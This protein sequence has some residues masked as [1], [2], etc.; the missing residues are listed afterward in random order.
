MLVSALLLAAL[1]TQAIVVGANGTPI[2]SATVTFVAA[3]G[4]KITARTDARGEAG[5]PFPAARIHAVAN[6]CL[7][8]DIPATAGTV[9]IQLSCTPPV[10]GSVSVAT[11]SLESIHRLPV[12]ASLMDGAQIAQS[13]A[14]TGDA[15]LRALPG[16]DMTRSNSRFTNYGQLR[17]S[18]SGAGQDRGLVLV[19]GVPAQDGFGGQIDWAAYP[20]N[21]ILRAELLRGAGSALYGSGAIGGVLSIS[22]FAPSSDWHSPPSALISLTAGSHVY[23]NLYANVA[24]PLAPKLTM[25]ASTEQQFM[26]Y[27]DLTPAYSTMHDNQAQ[28][29]SSM[30]SIRLR[31]D[32]SP[33]FYAM[34]GYRAGWDYQQQG[35]PNY[36]F[37]RR[38]YQN[39]VLLVH[40]TT[41]STTSIDYYVR[42][43]DVTNRADQF[44]A[45]PGVLR[46]TQ[47]VPSNESGLSSTWT[48]ESENSTLE[49]HGDAKF[50]NGES[51]QT[52]PTGSFQSLGSGVQDLGGLAAQET[53]LLPRTQIVAGARADTVSFYDGNIVSAKS[54]TVAAPSWTDRAVS[55]RI[56]VRYDLTRR[57]AFRISEGAGFRAPYLN[58]LVRSYQIGPIIY[59]NNPNL[60]PERSGSFSSG[61][62][63]TDGVQ[64]AS[65]DIIQ[66]VVSNAIAFRTISP[67]VQIRSNFGHTQTNGETLSYIRAIGRC[68]RVTLSGTSQYAR[69]TSGEPDT[70]GKRLQYVPQASATFGI[71]SS[72]GS[73]GTGLSVSYLGQTYADDLNLEPLGTSVVTGL[74]FGVPIPLGAQLDLNIDNLTNA[75]YMS[76]IDRYG[77][78]QV[79]SVGINVPMQARA[80]A[81]PPPGTCTR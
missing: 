32:A 51:E 75:R 80:A 15:L 26:Q 7:P 27:D 19:D 58:E 74:H 29:L 28:S 66:T 12:A 35:R 68:T 20:S 41:H 6:G 49:V 63:W 64:Q 44:P 13:T 11:G 33:G 8:A 47:S 46:Y 53:L 14:S 48:V 54:G 37:W 25:S 67:T 31:Y 45:K 2:A 72:V 21:D 18:F 69:V 78:P 59:L 43:A 52:G 24:T 77:P 81:T 17:A 79:I 55:P 30:A 50:V 36:D 38:L 57:L 34:Y 42:N 23:S 5:A 39:D 10:I 40:P 22:T 3:N 65:F 70:I 73:V 1:E 76:S 4:T 9:R 61:L 56:A 62:D 71:N 60:V 16:F